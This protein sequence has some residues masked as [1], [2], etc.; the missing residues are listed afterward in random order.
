MSAT[1]VFLFTVTR[2]ARQSTVLEY[3]YDHENA[4]N[5]SAVT[6]A[7]KQDLDPYTLQKIQ[8]RVSAY[9]STVACKKD[10]YRRGLDFPNP[11]APRGGV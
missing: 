5:E 6:Q 3:D 1:T 7:S 9:R 4:K 11:D 10:A 8:S 2:T